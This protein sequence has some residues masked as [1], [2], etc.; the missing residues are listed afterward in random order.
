MS[1]W[2]VDCVLRGFCPIVE[3]NSAEEA[4]RSVRDRLEGAI[5]AAA[6]ETSDP[7]ASDVLRSM[8]LETEVAPS[9]EEPG[10][11]PYDG[12]PGGTH[13]VVSDEFYEYLLA[14][15]Q[16]EESPGDTLGRLF[17]EALD[18]RSEA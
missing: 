11:F 8:D 12:S 10:S 5:A 15:Q 1:A 6:Q 13:I 9:D 3:A 4:A 16:A 2:T 7:V 18:S 17:R 14:N